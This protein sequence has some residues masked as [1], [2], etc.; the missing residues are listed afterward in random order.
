MTRLITSLLLCLAASVTLFA[1]EATLV[2][3]TFDQYENFEDIYIAPGGRGYAIS[4]CNS[5]YLTTDD[6]ESWTQQT[7]PAAVSQLSGIQCAPGTNCAK[8]FLSTNRGTYRKADEGSN[9]TNVINQRIH[10][11]DFS[12]S[13]LIFGYT[14]NGREF[15]RSNDDGLSWTPLPTPTQ[16]VDEMHFTSPTLFAMIGD[17]SFFR[18]LDGGANWTETYQFPDRAV[19]TTADDEGNYYVETYASDIFKSEDGGLTWMQKAEDAH[20][21]TAF[22][23]LFKDAEDSLHVISFNG[24]RFS[25]GDDGV[26]WGRVGQVRFQRYQNFRRAEGR[27]FAAG[28][29]LTLLAGNADYTGMKPLIS[30]KVVAFREIVFQDTNTGY[31]FGT[32]GEVFRTTD[33]GNNWEMVSQISGWIDGRPKVA[34]NGSLYGMVGVTS[35][36]S[37]T[38]Q[39]ITWNELTAANQVLDGG[40]RVFDILPNGEVV[41]MTNQRTVRLDAANNVVLSEDGGHPSVNGGTFDLKMINKD[42]GFIIRWARLDIY[43]TEDGGITWDTIPA[44]GGNNFFNWFDVE[45]ENT[46]AIGNGS[47]AWRTTDAGRTWAELNNRTALGRFTIGDDLYGF[48]RNRLYRTRD[49]GDNWEEKF[50]T[51]AQ[52]LDMVRRPGTNE[53]F[54]TYQNGIER[55]NI[56]AIL[57]PVRSLRPEAIS[58]RAIPNPT[59]GTIAVALPGNDVFGGTTDLFDL[60]GRRLNVPFSQSPGQLHLDM[61]SLKPGCYFLKYTSASGKLYQTKLIRN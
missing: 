48:N 34:P 37:S 14:A 45:D 43:R 1:Q 31:A 13:G 24:V 59:N 3:P 46:Y 15:Y 10:Q 7:P 25:S 53:I 4:S 21:Y 57:S 33:S 9:W 30:E 42:L 55:L 27:L 17:S 18:S 44:F 22:Y 39:G 60:T 32:D 61:S 51:C 6:G 58:L 49:G 35:F 8:V 12:Q 36:A 47:S 56:D 41:V 11:F 19:L 52:P 29:G 50:V 26:T 5:I 2:Y 20:Q 38:D 28:D 54:F 23:D 40:R 16:I